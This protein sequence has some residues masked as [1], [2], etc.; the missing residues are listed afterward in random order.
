M[1][2]NVFQVSDKVSE[3]T[4]ENKG[5]NGGKGDQGRGLLG[6]RGDHGKDLQN[7]CPKSPKSDGIEALARAKYV[8]QKSEK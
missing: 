1:N 4:C 5:Q 6:N 8:S 2:N 3:K 7:M